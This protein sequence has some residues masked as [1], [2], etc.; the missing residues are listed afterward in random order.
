MA[1]DLEIIAGTTF[2]FEVTWR[3]QDGTGMD[4]TDCSVKFQ[5]RTRSGSV[6]VDCSTDKGNVHLS[7]AKSG[8]IAVHIAPKQTASYK[9]AQVTSGYSPDNTQSYELRVYFPSGDVYSLLRGTARL[10]QGAIHD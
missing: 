2:D 4:I 6:L 7:D 9:P 10:I 1:P 3:N 8:V 5:I